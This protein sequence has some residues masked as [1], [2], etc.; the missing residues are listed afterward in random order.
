VRL[1]ESYEVLR[2]PTSRARYESQIAP[3]A[4]AGRPA[5]APASPPPDPAAEAR[6]AAVAIK[7]AAR[8]L[9]AEKYWD[10]IQLLEPAL[11]KAE[12]KPLKE[13]RV[14]L[15]RAYM[16][17]VNWLKQAE[18]LLLAVV[19]DDPNHV[20][21]HLLLA[22][23]YRDQGLKQRAAHMLKRVVE[24]APDNEQARAA[25]LALGAA[26]ETETGGRSGLL[27]RLFTRG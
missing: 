14:M 22:G 15:A 16:K 11:L 20:E 9:E 18:E 25:L 13:G 24:L 5:A 21:A 23:I 7:K 10:A 12:A 2:N 4:P 17:N 19:K 3:A 6:A 26:P 8:L 1:G 27:K